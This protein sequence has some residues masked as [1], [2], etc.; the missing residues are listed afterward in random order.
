MDD[1]LIALLVNA[2]KGLMMGRGLPPLTRELGSFEVPEEEEV[3]PGRTERALARAL[4]PWRSAHF[5]DW[6][7]GAALLELSVWLGGASGSRYDEI[8][9]EIGHRSRPLP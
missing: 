2:T 7:P 1:S 8:G 4:T 9:H 5:R 3:E 6:P